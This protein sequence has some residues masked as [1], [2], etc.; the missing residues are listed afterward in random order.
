MGPPG[1]GDCN[2]PSHRISDI[3]GCNDAIVKL[4]VAFFGD[5]VIE[6]V[7]FI[8]FTFSAKIIV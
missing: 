2:D 3:E 8:S 4:G 1:G 5:G 7:S 6:F